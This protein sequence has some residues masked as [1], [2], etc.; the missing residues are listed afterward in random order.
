MALELVIPF[1]IFGVGFGAY[2][3]GYRDGVRYCARQLGPLEEAARELA[4]LTRPK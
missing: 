3:W 1:I 4:A 2:L